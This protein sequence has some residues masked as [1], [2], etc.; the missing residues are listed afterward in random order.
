MSDSPKTDIERHMYNYDRRQ[1]R[2]KKAE[3]ERKKILSCSKLGFSDIEAVVESVR[4]RYLMVTEYSYA[5]KASRHSDH[6][7]NLF[8]P[9]HKIGVI[10]HIDE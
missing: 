6:R 3:F 7:P 9:N 8:D 2:T 1:Y 5:G 4:D 10:R